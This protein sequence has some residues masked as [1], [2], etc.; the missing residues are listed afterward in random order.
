MKWSDSLAAALPLKSSFSDITLRF[1]T[2][3]VL[4]SR[5]QYH[6]GDV[7][8]TAFGSLSRFAYNLVSP[9]WGCDGVTCD[10]E[11][12]CSVF[13]CVLLFGVKT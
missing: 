13:Y 8:F 1:S 6:F 7:M 4:T 12:R 11:K 5:A 9:V 3:F 10:A 2:H